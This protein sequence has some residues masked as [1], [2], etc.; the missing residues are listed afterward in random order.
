ME[1]LSR[2]TSSWTMHID[3]GYVILGQPGRKERS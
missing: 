1:I 3:L 2:L